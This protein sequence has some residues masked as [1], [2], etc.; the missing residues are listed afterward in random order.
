MMSLEFWDNSAAI[1]RAQK[2]Q[3]DLIDLGVDILAKF[4]RPM[5]YISFNYHLR[6]KKGELTG[7]I[8]FQEPF[9]RLENGKVALTYWDDNYQIDKVK[10]KEYL[11]QKKHLE[12]LNDAKI[13]S[14][15]IRHEKAFNKPKL[16][17]RAPREKK[18]W[19]A[20]VQNS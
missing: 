13:T 6:Q 10:E 19:H 14:E 15:K 12:I 8:R 2:D 11:I 17:M 20:S 18:R 9:V 3:E 1:E 16:I 5:P 7:R 4:G